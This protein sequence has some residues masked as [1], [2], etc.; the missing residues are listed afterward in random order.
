MKCGKSILIA[1]KLHQSIA[2]IFTILAITGCILLGSSVLD[3][4]S[5]KAADEEKAYKYY[6]SIEI[7]PGDS[8]WSI[9][10]E[11][12]S[13]EYD[14]VQE[15][16]DEVKSLNGLGDDEIHSG[17]FLIIPYYSYDFK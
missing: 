5:S 1:G 15:Y 13:E 10:M 2:A 3:A 11:Y 8:L 12:M 4:G 14:S 17:Q 16:V 9:A 7:A 6:T